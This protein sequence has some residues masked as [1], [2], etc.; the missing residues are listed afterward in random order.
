MVEGCSCRFLVEVSDY[1]RSRFVFDA[2]RCVVEIDCGRTAMRVSYSEYE[3]Q[4]HDTAIAV[5]IVSTVATSEVGQINSQ[6]YGLGPEDLD[7]DQQLLLL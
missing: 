1:V 3:R 2:M 4:Q 7:A 5:G 6:R